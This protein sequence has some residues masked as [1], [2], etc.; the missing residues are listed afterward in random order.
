[1]A[2]VVISVMP[3]AVACAISMRSKGLKWTPV[4]RQFF[5]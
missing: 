2:S 1:M 5:S 4:S 3:S